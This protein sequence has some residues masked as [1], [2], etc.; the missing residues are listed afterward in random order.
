TS[1]SRCLGSISNRWM[2]CLRFR[3]DYHRF[4]LHTCMRW[5]H[6]RTTR[7]QGD[8][9]HELHR[10]GPIPSTIQYLLHPYRFQIL[11]PNGGGVNQI[12]RILYDSSFI[13]PPR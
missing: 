2:W 11:S 3:A 13:K 4:G 7:A 8:I 12:T 10:E 9:Y 1:V 6:S 5:Y